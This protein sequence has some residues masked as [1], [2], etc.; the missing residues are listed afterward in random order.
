MVCV[1]PS[2]RGFFSNPPTSVSEPFDINYK[3]EALLED[4]IDWIVCHKKIHRIWDTKTRST[5]DEVSLDSDTTG[6]AH[7]KPKSS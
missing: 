6:S 5:S 2:R 7:K 3:V 4:V 1:Y